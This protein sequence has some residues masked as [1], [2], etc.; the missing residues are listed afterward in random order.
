MTRTFRD[1]LEQ[2]LRDPEFAKMFGAAQA[3][4]SFAIALS[5][6]RRQLNLTQ[7]QL[8]AR[9]NVSQSYVAKLEGGE[10]NPTLDKIGSLLAV[11]GFTLTTGT[12]T[13][14]PYPETLWVTIWARDTDIRAAEI[15]KWEQVVKTGKERLERL[16]L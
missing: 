4:S 7:Q 6:A 15:K 14:S 10:A 1:D 3:K 8:A 11:I 9:L 12:T 5:E 2:R 16:T 13:L